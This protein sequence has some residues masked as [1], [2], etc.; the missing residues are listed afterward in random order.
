MILSRRRNRGCSGGFMNFRNR[1]AIPSARMD[2][3][4]P[5]GN[6]LKPSNGARYQ[7]IGMSQ[8]DSVARLDTPVRQSCAVD[9]T[10]DPR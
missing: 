7:D 4:F 3:G 5:A 1:A 10:I 9:S 8:R 6:G 2:G